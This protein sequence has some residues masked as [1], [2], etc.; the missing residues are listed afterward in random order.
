MI[1]LLVASVA[2][3]VALR[4]MLLRTGRLLQRRVGFSETA[5]TDLAVTIPLLASVIAF[6]AGMVFLSK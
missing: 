1:A 6:V 4:I 2:L 3:L 5:L